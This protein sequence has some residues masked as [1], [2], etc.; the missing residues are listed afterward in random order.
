[1]VL[2]NRGQIETIIEDAG[3]YSSILWAVVQEKTQINHSC[4]GRLLSRWDGCAPRSERPHL[5]TWSYFRFSSLDNV[6]RG[7]S[8]ILS[9]WA[10]TFRFLASRC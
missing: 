4:H 10:L 2:V 1:M 8:F 6:E 7:I 3:T 5:R 9:L